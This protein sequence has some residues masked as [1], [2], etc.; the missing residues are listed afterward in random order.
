MAAR[1][2]SDQILILSFVIL[3]LVFQSNGWAFGIVSM[4]DSDVS[5]SMDSSTDLSFYES[6]IGKSSA[7]KADE[8][9]A[10]K[11]EEVAVEPK[12]P[13][14]SGFYQP[15]SKT[16]SDSEKATENSGFGNF[17]ALAG[18]G[19]VSKEMKFGQLDITNSDG[20]IQASVT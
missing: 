15:T 3:M 12:A 8:T 4:S 16:S 9:N 5:S 1:R 14:T 11:K 6:S 18:P 10:E 13:S 20:T 7:L 2:I 17:G 19:S